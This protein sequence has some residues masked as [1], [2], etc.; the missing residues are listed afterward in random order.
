MADYAKLHVKGLF[1]KNSDYSDPKVSMA[2]AAYALTPDEYIHTELQ[3]DT[4]S[5]TT[6]TTS[7]L[8]SATLLVV[9]NNDATNYVTAT[10]RSAGNGSTNNIVRIAA[11][12][13]LAVSDYTVA[14]NLLLVANSA[15]CECEVF[16]VG[17]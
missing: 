9:K 5:G 12:G 6:L 16:I 4:S 7:I 3:A 10:F 11:G 1:S 2:P 8:S 15:A 13:F 14:N 17:T